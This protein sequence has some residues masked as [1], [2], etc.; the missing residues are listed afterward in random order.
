MLGQ[1]WLRFRQIARA[2]R[3]ICG[4]AGC[5]IAQFCDRDLL[6]AFSVTDRLDSGYLVG[7]PVEG[8]PHG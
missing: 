4:T 1:A 3:C 7:R 2:Q 6:R 8:I 5:E